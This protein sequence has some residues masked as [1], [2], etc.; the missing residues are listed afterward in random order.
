MFLSSEKPSLLPRNFQFN[1]LEMEFQRSM[2][3]GELIGFFVPIVIILYPSGLRAF[4]L[5]AS[6]L[7]QSRLRPTALRP[8]EVQHT[9]QCVYFISPFICCMYIFSTC[10]IGTS[11]V[12]TNLWRVREMY[13][14]SIIECEGASSCHCVCLWVISAAPYIPP[15]VVHTGIA[16]AERTTN[17]T[18]RRLRKVTEIHL[19]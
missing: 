16:S 5:S 15:L 3:Q 19:E 17:R 9:T 6:L 14:T 4:D 8:Y 10:D 11:Q 7:N 13:T 18:K 1:P 2:F 12:Q